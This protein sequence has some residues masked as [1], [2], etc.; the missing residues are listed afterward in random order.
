MI[1]RNQKYVFELSYDFVDLPKFIQNFE[2]YFNINPDEDYTEQIIKNA[3]D[4]LIKMGEQYH[5][6]IT[7]KKS[8][9]IT[10]SILDTINLH[11]NCTEIIHNEYIFIGIS[12]NINYQSISLR[13][14]HSPKFCYKA[15]VRTENTQILYDLLSSLLINGDTIDYTIKPYIVDNTKA[16]LPHE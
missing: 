14:C 15:I 3:H 16:E 5:T 10:S 4:I 13:D 1:N 8:N 12:T 7:T 11:N 6:L 9:D 2:S